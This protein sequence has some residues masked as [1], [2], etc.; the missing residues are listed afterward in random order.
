MCIMTSMIMNTIRQFMAMAIP[1][2]LWQRAHMSGLWSTLP[3]LAL[4]LPLVWLLPLGRVSRLLIAASLVLSART[5][6]STVPPAAIDE[7]AFHV[8]AVAVERRTDPGS[9]EVQLR[10]RV[11]GGPD[12]AAACLR[13]R[14]AAAS[15]PDLGDAHWFQVLIRSRSAAEAC[16]WARLQVEPA[17]GS[18]AFSELDDDDGVTGDPALRLRR[19]WTRGELPPGGHRAD[20]ALRRL[21]EVGLGHLLAISGLHIGM[22]IGLVVMAAAPHF[23]LLPWWILRRDRRGLSGLAAPLTGLLVAATFVWRIGAPASAVRAVALGTAVLLAGRV[24]GR[25]GP[26]GQPLLAIT[27]LVALV[28]P[29]ALATP[30]LELSLTAVAW[31][32]PLSLLPRRART[33]VGAVLPWLGTAPALSAFAPVPWVAPAANLVGLPLFGLWVFPAAGLAEVTERIGFDAGSQ[34][35]DDAYRWGLWLLDRTAA[36]F[37]EWL[38]ARVA[39]EPWAPG[40]RAAWACLPIVFTRIL[41]GTRQP[42]AGGAK[43]QSAAGPGPCSGDTVDLP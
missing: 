5:A 11:L 36:V 8:W 1:L 30:G 18:G 15:A 2:A 25:R 40:L 13:G 9:Q 37:I 19:V 16:P 3:A 38:P 12:G 4:A 20:A 33:P 29:A 24:L 42:R 43:A 34:I 21:R 14:L 41:Q 39:I 6:T 23:R 26:A 31:L 35:A 17:V 10:L 28:D 32:T 7:A 22:L 27:L